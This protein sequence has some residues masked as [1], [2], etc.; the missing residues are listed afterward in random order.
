MSELRGTVPVGRVMGLWRYPV[1]SMAAEALD[2]VQVSW[3]GLAGD[4]R[5]AFIRRGAVGNGFPWFTLRERADLNQ[6]VPSFED[7]DKPD[8]S[9]TTLKT[10]SGEVFRVDDPALGRSLCEHGANVIKQN[11]GIFDTFPISLIS[12]QTIASLENMVSTEL[13]V[14]RFRPNILV[15][16]QDAG[17]FPEDSWVGKTLRIG[18]ARIRIDKRDGRCVVICI[19]PETGDRNPSV[20]KAVAKQRQQCLGVYASTVQPGAI[21]VNQVV[22]LEAS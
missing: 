21:A 20:L 5:W 4:R 15:D 2:S 7:S 18:D 13:G 19:D 11:R 10:P 9:R 6:F 22:H 14:T 1:K 16:A 8:T 3:F 17:D 12:M